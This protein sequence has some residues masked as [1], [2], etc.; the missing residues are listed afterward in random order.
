MLRIDSEKIA[1]HRKGFFVLVPVRDSLGL[2]TGHYKVRPTENFFMT[3][4]ATV[5][6]AGIISIALIQFGL[7]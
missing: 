3:E 4:M 2:F 1:P 6:S 7:V 5:C